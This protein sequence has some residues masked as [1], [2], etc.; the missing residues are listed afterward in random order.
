MFLCSSNPPGHHA[1]LLSSTYLHWDAGLAAMTQSGYPPFLSTHHLPSFL[2]RLLELIWIWTLTHPRLE[3]HPDLFWTALLPHRSPPATSK[4]LETLP[5][6][7]TMNHWNLADSLH[8]FCCS[9]S[10]LLRLSHSP[11]SRWPCSRTL[12]LTN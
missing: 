10:A 1:S 3:T 9:H 12:T 4:P 6:L 5:A 11:S 7:L 2:S 8:S